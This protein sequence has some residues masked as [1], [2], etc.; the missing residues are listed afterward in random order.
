[1]W[2]PLPSSFQFPFASF[3][4]ELHGVSF[5]TFSANMLKATAALNHGWVYSLAIRS[6]TLLSSNKFFVTP[7]TGCM[8]SC[9]LWRHVYR[10]VCA[11]LKYNRR[12]G[13]V[14]I[15]SHARSSL[16]HLASCW[17]DQGRIDKSSPN[18]FPS[19]RISRLSPHLTLDFALHSLAPT[20]SQFFI[21]NFSS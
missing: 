2:L 1:M 19:P 20:K 12:L 5:L 3:H 17:G 21:D 10:S 6:F 4:F 11:R 13:L 15:T 7:Y 18:C 16:L 14:I 9:S 8:A